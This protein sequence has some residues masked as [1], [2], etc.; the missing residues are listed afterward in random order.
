M[1]VPVPVVP[2]PKFVPV[3]E[4]PPP[5]PVPVPVV[6]VP[7]VLPGAV[8][9]PEVPPPEEPLV[10]AE[11]D[12]AKGRVAKLIAK[13]LAQTALDKLEGFISYGSFLVLNFCKFLILKHVIVNLI[14]Y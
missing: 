7:V 4:V 14:N 3:P 9:V 11:T 5:M 13:A 10:W 6:P 8:V 2:V 12:T 1:P